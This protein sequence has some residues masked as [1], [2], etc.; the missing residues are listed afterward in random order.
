MQA[1]PVRLQDA[2]G[3]AGILVFD[4]VLEDIPAHLGARDEQ[5]ADHE[6]VV[7]DVGGAHVE[8][9]GDLVERREQDAVAVLPAQEGAQPGYLLPAG[10][11]GVH[12]EDGRLR[13]GRPVRPET[14]QQ[15]GD[16]EDGPRQRLREPGARAQAVHGDEGVVAE[17]L[18]QP[19]GD[20]DLL[21]HAHLVERDARACELLLRLDEVARVRPEAGVVEGDHQV[22]GFA[23]E[24]RQ[25]FHLLPALGGILA[26]MGVGTGDDHGVP[27]L[28]A[29]QGAQHFDS[30]SHT[31][32]I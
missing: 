1:H 9:P 32:Q 31:I 23:G 16:A 26:A 10:L 28:G 18:P 24:S 17:L 4:L 5:V 8:E 12:R 6:R 27:A 21:R 15:V 11:A 25:P 22:A 13:D 14:V 3:G 20:G 7:F 19:V 30:F 29:H 2:E